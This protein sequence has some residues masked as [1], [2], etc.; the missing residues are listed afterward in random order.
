MERDIQQADR[1]LGYFYPDKQVGLAIDEWGVW[2]PEAVVDNGLEQANTLRD[3]VFAGACLNLFNNYAHR[4]TMSN[5]AQTINVLQC[6][7]LTRASEMCLTPTYYVYDMM[8]FHMGA[9]VLTY[10]LEC[11]S[12]EA[13]PVG[14]RKK[15][16]VPELSVSASISRKKILVTV[17][18]QT[19]DKDIEAR[20]DLRGAKV[21]GM[22]GRI[23]NSDDP[24]NAN[25]FEN[26]KTIFPKRIKRD[27]AGGDMV[28]VFPAHS[29]TSLSLTLA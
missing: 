18:N 12:F 17:A 29:L 10:E 16:S 20:I 14:L 1:V 24:R 21:G 22:I 4:V 7:A 2:H 11:P 23:L 3:A 25:T 9:R 8:R 5:I 26:P 15:H 28:Y 13:H 19:T 6:V 27:G